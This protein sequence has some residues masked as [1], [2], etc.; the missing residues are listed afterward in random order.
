MLGAI[1]PFGTLFHLHFVG[2]VSFPR[3]VPGFIG[4]GSWL[5]CITV[6]A[7]WI[8]LW[9]GNRALAQQEF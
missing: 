5:L 3:L 7:T 2:Q 6:A 8:P 4:A 1:L 9:F